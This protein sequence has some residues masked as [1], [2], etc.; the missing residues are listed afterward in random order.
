MGLQAWAT[1]A[2]PS[3]PMH[4]LTVPRIGY[5]H[6]WQSTQDEGWVRMGLDMYKI[7]YKYFGDN[8]VRKGNLRAQY[9]VILY[10]NAGV[11][12]DGAGGRAAGRSRHSRIGRRPRRRASRR[13]PTRRTIVA[14]VSVA[15]ACASSR[16]SSRTA[17]C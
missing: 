13:R 15:T 17:A 12:I 14:A 9:D 10:P 8:E 3:V 1:D 11:Q 16:S 6:S 4:D 7:P 2:A 5:I